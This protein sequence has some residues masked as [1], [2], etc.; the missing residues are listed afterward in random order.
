MH[1]PTE[2]PT[3]GH[4]YF[5]IPLN[6]AVS[7]ALFPKIIEIEPSLISYTAKQRQCYF[8]NEKSLIRFKYYTQKNCEVECLAYLMENALEC[9]DFHLPRNFN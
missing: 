3:H 7:A 6:Q 4:N 2:L 9:L 8:E 5:R 1:D